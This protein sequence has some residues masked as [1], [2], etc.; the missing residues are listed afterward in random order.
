MNSN[1][2]KL[3]FLITIPMFFMGC[4]VEPK[5]SEKVAH[6][7][8]FVE[9]TRNVKPNGKKNLFFFHV[10][11]CPN[12]HLTMNHLINTKS[13]QTLTKSYNRYSLELGRPL[14]GELMKKYDVQGG[15]VFVLADADFKPISKSPYG[16]LDIAAF[17]HWL[18]TGLSEP[19]AGEIRA[20]SRLLPQGH[21]KSVEN[22]KGLY[23]YLMELTSQYKEKDQKQ[24]LS[25]VSLAS[26]QLNTWSQTPFSENEA[27]GNYYRLSQSF[28]KLATL[29]E[30]VQ[31]K[32]GRPYLEKALQ[33]IRK[34]Q[35][36]DTL[37]NL[38]SHIL[39]LLIL[40]ELKNESEVDALVQKLTRL[41]SDNWVLIY[42]SL[43]YGYL[44]F[45]KNCEKVMT[46]TD[47]IPFHTLPV[48]TERMNIAYLRFQ[49]HA[50][51]N[52]LASAEKDFSLLQDSLSPE[53]KQAFPKK[54]ERVEALIKELRKK[55]KKGA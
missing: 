23:E 15:P 36:P 34:I 5:H 47:K 33:H 52:D 25:V 27:Y 49:C 32:S 39:E 19:P 53:I 8:G 13:F 29:A 43:A 22:Y 50:K 26:R 55:A 12:C 20:L 37:K 51:R 24:M 45:Q 28:W 16:F 30:A 4:T 35:S 18:E 54:F 14:G 7:E 42:G 17:T 6:P 9:Y 38:G 44:K 31:K 48:E 1:L 11:H 3:Y 21:S 46:Y 10:H 41:K 2:T 40:I